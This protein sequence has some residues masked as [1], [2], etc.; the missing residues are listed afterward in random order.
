VSGWPPAFSLAD[1]RSTGVA[2]SL[3]ELL[4]LGRVLGQLLV[5][6]R[7]P[8]WLPPMSEWQSGL[9]P[10]RVLLAAQAIVLVAMTVVTAGFLSATPSLVE[11]RPELG[12]WLIGLG[13]VYALSMV[14]RYV[15]RMARRP[16]ARWTGGAIPIVF[17][18]VLATWVLVLGSYLAGR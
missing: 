16:D 2:L 1:P 12:G 6:T 5:A 13:W 14:G 4:F 15:V 7:A 8:R 10:Y 18:I 17:H 3:L 11:R 9:L